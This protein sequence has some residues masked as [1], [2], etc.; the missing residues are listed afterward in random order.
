VQSFLSQSL[1][2]VCFDTALKI[3]I[4]DFFT[5]LSKFF[6]TEIVKDVL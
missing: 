5:D 2:S 4:C 6:W 1:P 3:I